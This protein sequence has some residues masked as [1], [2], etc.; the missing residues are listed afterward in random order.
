M[1]EPTSIDTSND[2]TFVFVTFASSLMVGSGV[3]FLTKSKRS[4]D[5]GFNFV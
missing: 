2:F 3:Y 1:S 5:D 4:A